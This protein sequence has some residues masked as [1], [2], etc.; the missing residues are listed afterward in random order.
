MSGR[1]KTPGLYLWIIR[2]IG[3]LVPTNSRLEWR[4]EWE[5]EIVSRWLL[6]K[7]WDRLDA[8]HKLDLLKRA[9]GAFADA[10]CFQQ[11]RTSLVLA[12]LN[13]VVGLLIG[14]GAVQEFIIRGIVDQQTQ[15]RLISLAGII[16]SILFIT[17]GVGLLR[18]WSSVHRLITLAGTLSVLLHVYAALPPHRNMGF[19]ALIVG[20]GYGLLMLLGF[21]WNRRRNLVL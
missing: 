8:D 18:R 11:G 17:C 12:T 19:L 6:L 10:L 2:A 1:I 20:A 7:E 5:A 3:L 9:H 4:R 14:F 16:V 15:P 13:M 21:E